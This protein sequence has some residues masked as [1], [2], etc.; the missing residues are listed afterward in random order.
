MSNN[1]YH[2]IEAYL[3]GEMPAERK[4]VFEQEIE[5]NKELAGIINLYKM[6]DEINRNDEKIRFLNNLEHAE[7]K[8]FRKKR[9]IINPGGFGI[10]RIYLAYAAAVVVLLIIAVPILF[11]QFMSKTPQELYMDYYT[12]YTEIIELRDAKSIEYQLNNGMKS[13]RNGDYKKAVSLFKEVEK[14]HKEL[15]SFYIAMS[16]MQLNS[17][18]E[19]IQYLENINKTSEYQQEA[20]WYM[21]LAYLANNDTGKARLLLTAIAND[22]GQFFNEKAQSLLEQLP[23]E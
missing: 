17:Y 14:H 18:T 16:Y 20:R 10:N 15:A 4:K 12:P 21:S 23:E 3:T 2:E 22:H 1:T 7:N 13:F 6:V 5:N 19:A 9:R 11:N 8:Y